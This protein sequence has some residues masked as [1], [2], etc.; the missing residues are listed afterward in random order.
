MKQL[1]VGASV[2]LV[3]GVTASLG[4][5][6]HTS[7]SGA[8]L[9]IRNGVIY[10]CVETRGNTATLGDIKLANCHAGFKPIHWNIRGRRGLR[11]AAGAGTPGPRGQVGPTGQAGPKGDKGDPGAKGAK[12]DKGDKGEPGQAAFGTFGPVHISDREDTGCVTDEPTQTPWALDKEDRLYVVAASQ[13]GSGYTVTRYDLHGTFKAIVGRQHPGC[14]DS[15]NFTTATTGTWNG[16][17]TQKVVGKFDYNP[18]AA[19]PTDPSWDSF[20]TAVFGVTLADTTF[21]SYEFDYYDSCGD[22][23]RDAQYTPNDASNESGTIGNC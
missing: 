8:Q 22:H 9:G 10:A 11:G 2:A 18:D 21:V 6:N 14:T 23:W 5:S 13:D 4:G 15:A 20:L 1:L 19:M 7:R 3:F 12:G 17:W 16:V